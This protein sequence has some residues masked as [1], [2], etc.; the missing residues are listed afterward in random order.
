MELCAHA[1][2]RFDTFV[3][4]N[5]F[6]FLTQMEKYFRWVPLTSCR[7]IVTLTAEIICVTIDLWLISFL[8]MCSFNLRCGYNMVYAT[9][10]E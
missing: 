5:L 10:D 8:V 4:M 3:G 6:R 2:C 9:C 7:E 1:G